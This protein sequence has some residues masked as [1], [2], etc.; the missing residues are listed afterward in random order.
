[1]SNLNN[2]EKSIE[3][4]EPLAIL[5]L[6]I[7]K[8]VTKQIKLFKNCNP[9]E[10]AFSF[11]KEN[12]LDFSSLNQI[13]EEIESLIGKYFN[14]LSNN[15]NDSN[16]KMKEINKT[17]KRN[18]NNYINI[19]NINIL[20]DAN[21]NFSKNNTI[22]TNFI[23][24]TNANK[25]FF[26]QFKENQIT[27]RLR[28]CHSREQKKSNIPKNP[29]SRIFQIFNNN[30][31]IFDRLYNDA[32]I[33]R[34]VYRRPCHFSNSKEKQK[35]NDN[36]TY[37]SNTIYHNNIN[38]G[39]IDICSS[40]KRAYQIKPNPVL[41]KECS[42]QPNYQPK[43]IQK[44]E[45]NF[46]YQRP[47]INTLNSGHKINKENID[48]IDN[49]G[50]L[51]SLFNEEAYVPL[52]NKIKYKN[53]NTSDDNLKIL[54]KSNKNKNNEFNSNIA[55]NIFY[56]LSNGTPLLNKKTM[57]IDNLNN[58][59]VLILSSVIKDINNS[60][61]E[62]NV[63]EFT[64]V[65]EEVYNNLFSDDRKYLMNNYNEI[66]RIFSGLPSGN[67]NNSIDS[68]FRGHSD[69]KNRKDKSTRSYSDLNNQRNYRLSTGT[70]KKK[71]FYYLY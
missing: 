19:N 9:G 46:N 2:F 6:E 56:K 43:I 16:E 55:K 59:T 23:N 71:N 58:K 44:Q 49:K 22:D 65:V 37:T 18:K 61:K 57:N 53:Y 4:E 41:S 24:N 39:T 38:N 42:F 48:I 30:S 3:N 28:K 67:K 13:K 25:L 31:N 29:N 60:S 33:K 50:T 21:F 64:K 45:Q 7:E 47:K 15:E 26:Y 62:M 32:K 14:P 63:D 51:N 68:M 20:S 11:C 8:G 34:L 52:K 36:L 1:M 54:E 27:S 70:E 35:T 12:N 40:Y 69:D 66:K 17:E 10:V 5:N